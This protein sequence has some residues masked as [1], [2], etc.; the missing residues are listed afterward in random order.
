MK[1]FLLFGFLGVL[2]FSCEN[3]FSVNGEKE[4]VTAVYGLLDAKRGANNLIRIQRSWLGNAPASASFDNPDSLY[5]DLDEIA[6]FLEEYAINDNGTTGELMNTFSI[7]DTAQLPLN[8]NGPFTTQGHYLYRVNEE[9]NEDRRYRLVIKKMDGSPDVT[10]ETDLVGPNILGATPGSP[11]QGFRFVQPRQIG[12][13]STPPEFGGTIEWRPSTNAVVYEIDV[14]FTYQD[15]EEATK[16]L[17]PEITIKLDYETREAPSGAPDKIS[18]VTDASG[19]YDKIA[20]KLDEKPGFLRFFKNMRVVI[21]A[22]G[23]DLLRYAELNQPLSGVAQT[24]PEFP[25][26]ENGIGLFSSRTS[27]SID[28]V[29][30]TRGT[31]GLENKFFL[32]SPLCPLRFAIASA[33]D[34]CTCEVVGDR[35]EK[36]VVN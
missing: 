16:K 23:E 2:L 11:Q 5:Y 28:N 7:T 21:Y 30:L 1:K 34:T 27:V 18:A 12:S 15:Y 24:R 8:D 10:S 35:R 4:D 25:G 3:D 6:V 19:F 33:G 32:S 31:N 9:L 36:V 22:G 29:I 26:V 20:G 14:F 13:T 17:G